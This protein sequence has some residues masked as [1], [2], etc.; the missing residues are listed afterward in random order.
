MLSSKCSPSPTPPTSAGNSCFWS[1]S[2]RIH[3]GRDQHT[4]GKKTGK[5]SYF[6]AFFEEKAEF[7]RFCTKGA[8]TCHQII[9][10]S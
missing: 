4:E 1:Y 2:M 9:F 5:K 7:S 10:G 8:M 6:L 3:Y